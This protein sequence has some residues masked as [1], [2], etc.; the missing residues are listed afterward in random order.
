MTFNTSEIHDMIGHFVARNRGTI[1]DP[2]D[3]HVD[4]YTESIIDIFSSIECLY[5]FCIHRMKFWRDV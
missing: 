2:E 5:D 1:E 4:L 3:V